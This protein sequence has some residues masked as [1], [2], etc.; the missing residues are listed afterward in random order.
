M[1]TI[2]YDT[3]ANF[4]LLKGKTIAIIGYGAQGRAQAL[5]LKDSGADVLVGFASNESVV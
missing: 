4:D 3:D 5:N 2:Y 1:A